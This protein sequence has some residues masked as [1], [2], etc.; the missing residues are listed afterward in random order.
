MNG[1]VQFSWALWGSSTRRRTWVAIIANPFSGSGPNRLAVEE[2][3]RELRRHEIE[4]RIAWNPGE[5]SELLRN[6]TPASCCRCVV[7]AGGD[8]TIAAI[9]NERHD[10]PLAV[11]PLG[12]ENLFAR[13][14]GLMTTPACLARAIAAGRTRRVDLGRV[15]QGPQD[16]GGAGATVSRERRFTIVVS[17]GFDAAVVHR[18]CA[19]RDRGGSLRRVNRLSYAKPILDTAR[20]YPYPEIVVDADGEIVRGT[21]AFVFNLPQYGAQLPIAP[22]A[23]G[24]DGY[25]DWLVFQRP[26]L[27]PLVGYFVDVLRGAHLR[28]PDVRHGRARHIR[29]SSS[30]PAPLEIDGDA[31]GRTP[32]EID[33]LSQALRVI[34]V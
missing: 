24:C 19:W 4:P 32:A 2:L 9:I 7:A 14:F 23:N 20:N 13:Q 3:A 6:A 11:L 26:G 31:A 34:T 33:V 27:A 28:R 25:L 1:P 15:Q 30:T 10:L 17:A 16:A 21:H 12:S 29:V 22:Q 5:Q 18:V 8:G